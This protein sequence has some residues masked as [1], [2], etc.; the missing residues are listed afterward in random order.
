MIKAII[1]DCFG[2]L[3]SEGWRP[4]RQAHFDST[5]DRAETARSIIRQS[6]EGLIAHEEFLRQIAALAGV[7]FEEAKKEIENNIPNHD[8]LAFI[9]NELSEYK[10]GLLSNVSNNRLSEFL[11]EEEVKRFDAICLSYEIGVAKPDKAAYVFVA[12]KLGV[13]PA[14]CVFVDD[15]QSYC[16]GAKA[17]GMNAILFENTVQFIESLRHLEVQYAR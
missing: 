3:A 5:P 8:L 17:A 9:M 4:F 11:T 2:V 7:S 16:D 13:N 10:I 1:F 12:E 15:K 6:T 14:E